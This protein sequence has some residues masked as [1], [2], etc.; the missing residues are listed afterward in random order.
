LA[1][2]TSVLPARRIGGISGIARQKEAV[3]DGR[4]FLP[5]TRLDFDLLLTSREYLNL[6]TP[7]GFPRLRL[8]QADAV[9][10]VESVRPFSIQPTAN[11]AA[12]A[13]LLLGIPSASTAIRCS[14]SRAAVRE[15][16][17]GS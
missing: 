17:N 3:V 1:K 8:S 7:E 9:A 11:V 2:P 6:N 16:C 12:H 15:G 4:E 14:S 10:S 13:I 5:V